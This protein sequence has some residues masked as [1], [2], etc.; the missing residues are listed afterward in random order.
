MIDT[1]EKIIKTSDL[2][3]RSSALLKRALAVFYHRKALSIP[4]L[5]I[6]L[7]VS[8]PT[9]GRLASLLTRNQFVHLI[10]EGPSG[11]GRKPR[12]YQIDDQHWYTLALDAGREHLRIALFNLNDQKKAESISILPLESTQ[13]YLDATVSHIK[14]FLSRHHLSPDQVLGMGFA[15]PG[16]INTQN[17][18]SL[19]HFTGFSRPVNEILA[20]LTG[21]PVVM[22]N[23]ARLM[24]KGEASFGKARNA[25]NAIYLFVDRGV[26]AGLVVNGDIYKG[27]HGYAGEFGH[28]HFIG[29]ENN[30]CYCG[31]TDCLET[32]TNLYALTKVAGQMG[33]NCDISQEAWV[34]IIEASWRGDEVAMNAVAEIGRRLGLALVNLVHLFDP[35]IIIVGGSMAMAGHILISS[36][37][38]TLREH[39]MSAFR[40][41]LRLETS[42]MGQDACL[43]G[44]HAMVMKNFFANA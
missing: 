44:C 25:Q 34:N 20:D 28:T 26:G 7:G 18:K 9:A 40:E 13:L 41:D 19:V 12:I 42:G 29:N 17:S 24:A 3:A 1:F 23:D 16:L 33:F 30:A 10:G 38:N 31:Q 2:Q 35:E 8:I 21:I 36:I 43:A 14:R 27:N 4:A 37:F 32:Y 6:E 11:G 5:A 15:V 39:C 22:D